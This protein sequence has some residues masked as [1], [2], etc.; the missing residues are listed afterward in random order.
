MIKTL[1]RALQSIQRFAGLYQDWL[2]GT[3][4]LILGAAVASMAPI[5]DLF[6]SMII[7]SEVGASKPDALIFTAAANAAKLAPQE[8]IHIG[9]DET[10]DL[11]GA[12]ASGFV[13]HL[14]CR[15]ERGLDANA[16]EV[17]AR[18]VL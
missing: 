4:A 6:E 17:L 11:I 5:G 14:V 1:L 16:K 2:S 18:A 8:C 3:D 12:R 13:A 7:S 9:D 10:C 15:P